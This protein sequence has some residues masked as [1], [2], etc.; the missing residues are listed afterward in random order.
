MGI[1]GYLLAGFIGFLIGVVISCILLS[2]RGLEMYNNVQK[3][4]T[5]SFGNAKGLYNAYMTA[6]GEGEDEQPE[7]AEE[8]G[9]TVADGDT[10]SALNGVL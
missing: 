6:M 10:V 7:N 9:L 4:G 5:E 8:A 3:A 1:F 2:K